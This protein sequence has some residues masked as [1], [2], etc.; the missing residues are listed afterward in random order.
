[1]VQPPSRK[2]TSGKSFVQLS[3]RNKEVVDSNKLSLKDLFARRKL[4]S[5]KSSKLFSFDVE[6]PFKGFK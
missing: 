4:R 1:L 2:L 6:K 3:K 5:E